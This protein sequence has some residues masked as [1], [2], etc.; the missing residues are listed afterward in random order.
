MAGIKGLRPKG[1]RFPP[2]CYA[3]PVDAE[4]TLCASTPVGTLIATAMRR[5]EGIFWQLGINDMAC[6]EDSFGILDVPARRDE[7]SP[8]MKRVL[9]EQEVHRPLLT[10]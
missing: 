4:V 5:S 1:W 6:T 8:S 2:G 9:A 10:G 3:A 7:L